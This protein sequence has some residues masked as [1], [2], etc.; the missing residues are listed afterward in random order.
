MFSIRC[1]NIELCSNIECVLIYNVFSTHINNGL[2]PDTKLPNHTPDLLGFFCLSKSV[3][4]TS[5]I[6]VRGKSSPQTHDVA[7]LLY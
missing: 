4:F 1:S 6:R 7:N 5:I 3:S 2:D